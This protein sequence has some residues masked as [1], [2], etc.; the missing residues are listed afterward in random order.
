MH[1]LTTGNVLDDCNRECTHDDD[2][3]ERLQIAEHETQ[4]PLIKTQDSVHDRFPKERHKA[5]VSA[6][7]RNPCI[8]QLALSF[9]IAAGGLQCLVLSFIHERV[10]STAPLPD[11]AFDH[12]P[13]WSFGLTISEYLMLTSM[14]VMFV[15]AAMHRHRWI[16]LR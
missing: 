2:R 10:P 7:C 5:M 3:D 16:L 11:V 6:N 1:R 13:Y 14:T 9:A 15:I 8:S 12:L 4:P